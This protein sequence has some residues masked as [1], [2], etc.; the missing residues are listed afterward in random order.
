MLPPPSKLSATDEPPWSEAKKTLRKDTFL[1]SPPLSSYSFKA[2]IC[3]SNA[4]VIVPNSLACT[5]C[6]IALPPASVNIG[7]T[8][9]CTLAPVCRQPP[10]FEGGQAPAV[11]PPALLVLRGMLLAFSQG[12]SGSLTLFSGGQGAWL[13]LLYLAT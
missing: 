13:P 9:P 7:D 1:S 3:L 8:L 10:I 4:L 12:E 5:L 11:S 6:T 2:R